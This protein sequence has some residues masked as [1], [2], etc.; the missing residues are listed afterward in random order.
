FCHVLLSKCAGRRHPAAAA[1]DDGAFVADEAIYRAGTV[2][3]DW[4]YWCGRTCLPV[5][6]GLERRLVVGAGARSGR[7]VETAVCVEVQS[8][9]Y[10]GYSSDRRR[11]VFRALPA[12]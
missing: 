10:C 11:R 5:L 9:A 4:L 1:G 3:S 12:I 7:A 2:V 8:G 6:V